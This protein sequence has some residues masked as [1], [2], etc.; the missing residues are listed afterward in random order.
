[1]YS[2]YPSCYPESSNITLHYITLQYRYFQLALYTVSIVEG[3]V[4]P[5]TSP[6]ATTPAG[7]TDKWPSTPSG[8]R[9]SSTDHTNF[10]SDGRF[11]T[12]VVIVVMLIL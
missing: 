6:K 1:M 3:R 2:V 7:S 5:T 11:G 8:P 12:I 10:K 9:D 4:T